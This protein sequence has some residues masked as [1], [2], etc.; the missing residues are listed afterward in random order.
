LAHRNRWASIETP[1]GQMPALIPPGSWSQGPP[2]MD[3]VP[4]VGEH[5]DSILRKL[6]KTNLQIDQMR[7]R[8]SI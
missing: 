6:G 4:E 8:G 2:R 1:V 7:A 5:T 3:A